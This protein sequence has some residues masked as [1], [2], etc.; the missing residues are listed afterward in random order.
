MRSKAKMAVL[1]MALISLLAGATTAAAAEKTAKLKPYTLDKCVV[2]DEKLGEMG[3]PFVHEYKGR[4][5]KFCCKSCL[6][7]F[8]K[9]PDKY[10]KKIEEAEAKKK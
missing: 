7:D 3:K 8:N 9:N 4:E 2:S 5:I 10:V 6:K 1:G